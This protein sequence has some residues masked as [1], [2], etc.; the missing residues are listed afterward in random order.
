[1]GRSDGPG[2]RGSGGGDGTGGV[3]PRGD[4]GE[5]VALDAGSRGVGGGGPRGER[6][7]RG[8]QHVRH[9]GVVSA[10]GPRRGRGVDFHDEVVPRRGDDGRGRGDRRR[11]VPVGRDVPGDRRGEPGVR[12][13][14]HGTVRRSGVGRRGATP[15]GAVARQRA[16]SV[17]RVA[18]PAGCSDAADA[19]G[20][21]LS[22]RGPGGDVPAG[23]PGG[24]VGA[25]PRFHRAPDPRAGE[26]VSGRLRECG[27]VR[28]RRRVRRGGDDV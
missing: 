13:R 21:A 25:L 9:A 24:G 16:E 6:P 3:P 4:A 15:G 20:T 19:D 8:G 28:R 17:R 23:P 10:V 27:G 2:G 7:V 12:D 5:S 11:V 14:L 1:M 22:E 26:R 18:D